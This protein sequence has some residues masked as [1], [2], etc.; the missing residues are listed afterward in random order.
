MKICH[1]C[2]ETKQ[3][4][5]FRNRRA[6][7]KDGKHSWCR[8]CC[9]IHKKQWYA[10]NKKKYRDLAKVWAGKRRIVI[11][12]FLINFL[13]NNPCVDCSNGNVIVLDFDHRG[14]KKY[15]ISNMMSSS[16]AKVKEEISKCDVR[17]ANCHRI[18]T[19][20]QF[21]WRK[22]RIGEMGT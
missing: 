8:S 16:I 12:D 5:E 21:N 9:D 18:K 20:K 7:K 2:K 22:G 4:S 13:R 19:A 3:L 15:N 1:K 14:D 11:Q 17:C 10:K 6:A